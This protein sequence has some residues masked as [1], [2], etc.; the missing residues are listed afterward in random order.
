MNRKRIT[1]SI[2]CSISNF[3]YCLQNFWGKPNRTVWAASCHGQDSASIYK[4]SNLP[5]NWWEANPY[6]RAIA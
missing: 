4:Q 5:Q 1:A 2:S 3:T 6:L